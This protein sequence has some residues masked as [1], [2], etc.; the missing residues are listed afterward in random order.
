M[1]A[2]RLGGLPG[3]PRLHL[4]EMI[5]QVVVKYVVHHAGHDLGRMALIGLRSRVSH[6]PIMTHATDIPA[7]ERSPAKVRTA[8]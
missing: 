4:G 6:Q 1:P 3:K 8:G 2:V 7:P 5:D